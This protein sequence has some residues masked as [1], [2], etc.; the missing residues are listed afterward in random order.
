[1]RRM[2]AM[3][4]CKA[5][6]P[7]TIIRQHSHILIPLPLGLSIS[8]NELND[9]CI[10]HLACQSRGWAAKFRARRVAKR[11]R[12]AS[13][14]ARR[15]C[16]ELCRRRHSDAIGI[17]RASFGTRRSDSRL[18][19]VVKAFHES[20]NPEQSCAPTLALSGRAGLES[21]TEKGCSGIRTGVNRCANPRLPAR[22]RVGYR[23]FQLKAHSL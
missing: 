18:C 2:P 13:S 22:A 19:A 8:I 23:I 5:A 6:I 4:A 10:L 12:R 20:W 14:I 21:S 15:H 11:L 1:M 17:G 9:A 16:Q 7:P 3:M